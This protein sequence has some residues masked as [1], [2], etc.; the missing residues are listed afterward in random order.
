MDTV[1]CSEDQVTMSTLPPTHTQP[2]TRT[3]KV[4]LPEAAQI[5]VEAR[6][7]KE[8]VKEAVEPAS[9]SGRPPVPLLF[10]VVCVSMQSVCVCVSRR[11][12]SVC[13]SFANAHP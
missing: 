4:S 2:H 9:A 1:S 10:Q 12:V 13:P 11:P 3:H 8:A 5:K 6:S 7:F